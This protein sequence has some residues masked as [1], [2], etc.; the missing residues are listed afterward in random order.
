MYVYDVRGYRKFPLRTITTR[1]PRNSNLFCRQSI[2][3][4]LPK[5]LD[6]VTLF[7]GLGRALVSP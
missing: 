3:R 2:M 6:R 5:N 4:S 1:Y 7:A